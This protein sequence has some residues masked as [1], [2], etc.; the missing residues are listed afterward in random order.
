[1]KLTIERATLARL[2]ANVGRVVESR[3]T[4]PILGFVLLEASQDG[5]RVTGTDLDIVATDRAPAET[6]T[7]GAIC[8]DAKLL[9]DIAKKAGGDISISLEADKLVVKS[10][11]SR[12]SLQTLPA[13]DFPSLDGGKFD[14]SFEIDLAAL[15]APVAFAISN[16]D[17]RYYLQGVYFA[18]SE[19]VSVAVATDGHRLARHKAAS[20]GTFPGVI[21][22]KKVVGLLPKGVAAVSVSTTKIRIAI[23]DFTLV[24]KLIDGTFPDYER[25][26]PREN[27]LAVTADKAELLRAA[28]RVTTVSNERGRAVKLSVA[29][30][31][32]GLSVHSQVGDAQ[33]E[34]ATEYSGEPAE[35]GFNSVYLRDA[36]SAMADGQVTLS[37]R[38]AGSPAL[39]TGQSEALDI[40]LM[41]MRV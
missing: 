24:S 25:V 4:I 36:L 7:D 22:P 8:V 40:T 26:I 20:L 6:T 32:I 34:V 19:A 23:G 13:A 11:R 41:P 10:G 35:I 3:N 12:F 18:S 27:E 31:S 33:D 2:L 15:F 30:G 29:S 39:L 1:M 9:S 17:V 21:V 37:L 14:A 16:D 38:D 5:L 28:D